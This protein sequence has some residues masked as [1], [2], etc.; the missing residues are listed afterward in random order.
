[1]SANKD[2]PGPSLATA[3]KAKA[4]A[5]PSMNAKL[6]FHNY[7]AC[8]A[9]GSDTTSA[10]SSGTRRTLTIS[11][12]TLPLSKKP[13][14]ETEPSLADVLAAIKSV[15]NKVE[16][17]G[18]QLKTNSE[19]LTRIVKQVDL[20]SVNITKCNSKV[21]V[22]EKEHSDL[23]EENAELKE[24]LLETERYKRRWNLRLLGL[25]EQEGENLRE[26]VEELL[27]ELFPKWDEQIEDVVDSVHRVGRREKGRSHQI[28]M[29]FA[30][31][32]HRDEVWKTTKDSS[33]CRDRGLRFMQDYIKEDRQAREQLWPQVKQAR[34]LGKV[35]FYRGHIAIIDGQIVMA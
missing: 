27:L 6:S 32:R 1:M 26:K 2:L 24:R 28:I 7:A 8:V 25:K 9:S 30:R 20:N 16:V 14:L 31:R 12:P 35:A 17:F 34:S 18:Q 11:P 29:Q 13:A 22:L 10:S 4:N 33:V 15:D 21:E 19:M 5:K 23:K 3:G